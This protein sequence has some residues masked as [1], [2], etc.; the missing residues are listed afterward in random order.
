MVSLVNLLKIPQTYNLKKF[1]KLFLLLLFLLLSTTIC[2]I[3]LNET[4]KKYKLLLIKSSYIK[5]LKL[6]IEKFN[7]MQKHK[8]ENSSN[9]VENFQNIINHY[10]KNCKMIIKQID[11]KNESKIDEITIDICNIELLSWHDSYIFE[12]A[13]KIQELSPG[14][15]TLE[16]FDITRISNVNLKFPSLKARISCKLYYK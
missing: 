14:F 8:F 5:S 15:V 10:S 12:M 13:D 11:I 2:N 9:I 3:Y 6:N 16:S 1:Y 7:F 4:E